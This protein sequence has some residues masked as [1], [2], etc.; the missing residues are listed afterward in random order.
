M[1]A[2]GMGG[3]GEAGAAPKPEVSTSTAQACGSAERRLTGAGDAYAA[4]ARAR[5]VAYS[6]P[7]G[8]PVRTF[9]RLNA[10]GYPTVLGV[11]AAV[12]GRDCRAEWY[13]V[14]LPVR[15][16]GTSAYVRARAVTISRVRTRI[17]VDLSDRRVDLFRAGRRVVS[18]RTAIGSRDTPTPT[19]R[20]YVNQL[21]L[22]RDPSGPFGPGAIGISAFSPVLTG[23][24][25]GG[26]I[27]IHGTNVPSSIGYAMSHGCLRI[28]NEAAQRLLDG[29]PAGTPV[30]IRE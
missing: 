21:L 22:A 1:L 9:G 28:A 11:L 14:Q 17:V 2:A 12:E 18:T 7:D 16:N 26:P 24:V 8:R 27:A 29:T 30:L 13:R 6:R 5:L 25:Q 19:G 3:A 23:W 20:Y 15:P 4:V 10:N